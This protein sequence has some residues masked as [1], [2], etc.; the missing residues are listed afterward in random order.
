[1]ATGRTITR[2]QAVRYGNG[3]RA[4]K[5]E[6]LDVVCAVTGYHRDYACR[7]LRLALTPRVVKARARRSPKCDSEVVVALEKCWA[8]ASAP[9]GKPLAPLLAELVAVLR[10]YRELD[11]DE[12]T[13]ALMVSMSAATIDRR[14]ALA[15]SRLILKGRCHTKPGSLVKSRI[16][17]RT[18]ADHDENT[19][20][21]VEIDLVGHEGGNPRGEF[22]FTLTVT[23][24]ATGWT[25]NQSVLN[26]AQ[27]QVLAS[28]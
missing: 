15:R 18:W 5:S 24:I 1:M 16:P 4:V 14:L 27:A 6:I 9:A 11:I 13:A 20:G 28:L 23:N 19:S 25:E 26:K 17:M 12:D 21:F 7:A 2:A 3:S 22:C 8:V 10:R